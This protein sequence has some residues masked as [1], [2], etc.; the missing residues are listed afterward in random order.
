MSENNN[1]THM[2]WGLT[3]PGLLQIVFIILKLTHIID[4]KWVWVLAPLWMSTSIGLIG[5]AIAWIIIW[6]LKR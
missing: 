5:V 1:S 2:P 4:W 3:F 6:W